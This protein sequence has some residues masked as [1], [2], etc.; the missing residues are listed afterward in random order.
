MSPSYDV[1]VLGTGGVGSA[2]M[3]HLAK[4]GAKVLGL[5]RFPPG[6]DRG[7]SHGRTRIIRQ[8]YFEHPDYVP[9]LKRAYDLWSDLSD[10]CGKQLYHEIGLLQIGPPDG[11]VI[12]G[13]LRSAEQ[14]NLSVQHLAAD[15]TQRRFPGFRLSD[16]WQAVYEQHAGYLGVENCVLAHLSEAQNHGAEQHTGVEV[17]GWKG[18]KLSAEISID[19]GKY[20]VGVVKQADGTFEL[21]ADWWGIETTRGTTEKEFVEELNQQYAYQRVVMAC[22]DQGYNLEETKNEETGSISLTMKKWE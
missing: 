13:A 4:R 16:G 12:Q 2:A 21:V 19:M 5:D 20:D 1:I 7:S 22:E 15:E 8:A 18:Q 17:R 3:F 14:H 9:L 10:G 11:Q 6:H